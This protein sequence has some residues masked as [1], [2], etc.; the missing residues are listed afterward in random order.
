MPFGKNSLLCH[1][2]QFRNYATRHIL[3][4]HQVW[5]SVLGINA[6]ATNRR[7]QSFGKSRMHSPRGSNWGSTAFDTLSSRLLGVRPVLRTTTTIAATSTQLVIVL[8]LSITLRLL[9]HRVLS[10]MACGHVGS[11]FGD[12]SKQQKH[13]HAC[14]RCAFTS[15]EYHPCMRA[16]RLV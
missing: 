14:A 12:V 5:W 8:L 3:E 16:E 11:R 1:S 10:V 4:K 6:S 13:T 2:G 15:R 9:L 7:V